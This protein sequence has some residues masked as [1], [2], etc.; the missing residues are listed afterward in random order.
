MSNDD[1]Q[2]HLKFYLSLVLLLLWYL[3]AS[4]E[5]R[6]SSLGNILCILNQLYFIKSLTFITFQVV[7]TWL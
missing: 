3:E 6:Q 5:S 7:L 2:L 1:L 4:E